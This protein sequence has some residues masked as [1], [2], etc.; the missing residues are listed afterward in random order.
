V[1]VRCS[2][3][4]A[5]HQRDIPSWARYVKCEYCGAIIQISPPSLAK[6]EFSLEEFGRFLE[7]RKKIKAFDPVSGILVIG[8]HQISVDKRGNISGSEVL[9]KRVEKWLDEYMLSQ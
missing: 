3:C 4:G 1:S 5:P 7:N 8:S 9:R 6:K 2:Q